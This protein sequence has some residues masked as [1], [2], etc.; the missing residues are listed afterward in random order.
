MTAVASGI[1]NQRAPRWMVA[2]LV[3]SLALNLAVVGAAV[4]SYW[5]NG[6]EPL[7]TRVGAFVPRHELGYAVSLP[8]DRVKEIERLTEQERREVGP[9]RRALLEAR[10]ESIKALTAEPF[11][12]QRYLEA[13]AK[14]AAADR[15]SREAAFKL[16]RAIGFLLTPEERR[17]FVPWRER[18]RPFYNP[19]DAPEKQGTEPQR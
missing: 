12:R 15:K 1:D 8:A 17:N 6:W 11:D 9:L 2:A 14:L 13:H 16:H 19:L 3:A 18:Q 10:A 4:S 7:G 5:R